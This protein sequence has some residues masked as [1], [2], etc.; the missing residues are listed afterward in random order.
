MNLSE[1]GRYSAKR[2]EDKLE[3]ICEQVTNG[4]MPDHKYAIF[5]RNA[6][7]Q[8]RNASYL[9]AGQRTPASIDS[10]PHSD[11]PGPPAQ[12]PCKIDSR[13]ETLRLS[14]RVVSTSLAIAVMAA[15][16]WLTPYITAHEAHFLEA[17]ASFAQMTNPY[18]GKSSAA[19]AGKQ[20]YGQNCAQCHGKNLQGVGPAPALDSQSVKDAK[21]GQLFWFISTGNVASGMPSW[22]GLPKNQRWQIVTFLQSK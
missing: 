15:T 17:P 7:S 3:E 18:Q 22:S 14:A 19:A 4:E 11:A 13:E 21:P 20:L 2:K 12:S 9:P 16:L 5:H 1:W 6:R 8:R 10:P